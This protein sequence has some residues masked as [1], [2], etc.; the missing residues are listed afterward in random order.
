V[1]ST[2]TD[3]LV[4]RDSGWAVKERDRRLCGLRPMV[5]PVP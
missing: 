1:R 2:T 3:A 5:E 4:W